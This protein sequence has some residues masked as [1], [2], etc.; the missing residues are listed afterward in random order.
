LAG[1]D[2]HLSIT[3]IQPARRRDRGG[4][5]TMNGK[6]LKFFVCNPSSV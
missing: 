3:R 1:R 4:A 2:A 5:G 6:R